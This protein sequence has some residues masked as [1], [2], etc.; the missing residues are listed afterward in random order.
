MGIQHINICLDFDGVLHDQKNA[1]KGHRM[2]TPIDGALESVNRLLAE[3]HHLV[4]GTCRANTGGPK[5]VQDW[6]AYFG[7]PPLEVTGIKPIAHCYID[8]RALRFQNWIDTY[9]DIARLT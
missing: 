4:V 5:H 8:D 6:M 7:F 1:P 9:H 3:G 2:G